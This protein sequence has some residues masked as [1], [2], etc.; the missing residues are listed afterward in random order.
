MELNEFK[1]YL[2]DR[3][4]D[5]E[6]EQLWMDEYLGDYTWR[7]IHDLFESIFAYKKIAD[8]EIDR[9]GKQLKKIQDIVSVIENEYLLMKLLLDFSKDKDFIIVDC[10]HIDK[11]ND[12]G[13]RIPMSDQGVRL[14]GSRHHRENIQI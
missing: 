7:D 6:D 12:V 9:R 14:T 10:L 11:I 4:L 3:G 5:F 8:G 13:R 2:Q 1:N